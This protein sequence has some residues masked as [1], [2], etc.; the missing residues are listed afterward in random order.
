MQTIHV[1][2]PETAKSTGRQLY[3]DVVRI[4]LRPG[5]SYED[6]PNSG[7]MR[8]ILIFLGFTAVVYTLLMVIFSGGNGL[9]L[10]PLYFMNA[11]LMPWITAFVLF[12]IFRIIHP[13]LF[14]RSLLLGI[15]AYAN[16]VLLFAWIPG[17]A[18]LAEVYKYY[19]IGLGL[20]KTRNIGGLKA[21]FSL[22]AT[23]GI[24]LSAVYFLQYLMRL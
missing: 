6:L 17:L 14:P 9:V 7:S 2:A 15:T 16:V 11:M 12:Y 23:A 1:D 20:V 8:D 10:A 5:K 22:L 4:L 21:F 19:L 18:P 24:L 3:Q 13:G